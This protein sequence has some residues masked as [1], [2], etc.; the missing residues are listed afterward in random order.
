[1][2]IAEEKSVMSVCFVLAGKHL[3]GIVMTV[4][5]HLNCIKQIRYDT[6]INHRVHITQGGMMLFFY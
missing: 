3:V 6:E 1:M 4:T 2:I 5:A